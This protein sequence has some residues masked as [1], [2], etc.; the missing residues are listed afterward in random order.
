MSEIESRLARLERRVTVLRRF[1]RSLV[2]L[3]GIAVVVVACKSRAAAHAPPPDR[4][5]IKD[6]YIGEEGVMIKKGKESV[7]LNEHGLSVLNDDGTGARYN[8]N[9]I[10]LSGA[11]GTSH[12][13]PNTLTLE[14]RGKHGGRIVAAVESV[15]HDNA[16]T[17]SVVVRENAKIGALVPE[18]RP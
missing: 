5:V 14:A 15:K 12:L 11:K 4:L 8:S 7:L 18:T 6:V 9:S 1:N 17:A 2:L 16:P 13:E 3:I 10:L